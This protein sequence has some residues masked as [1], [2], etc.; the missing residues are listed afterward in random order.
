MAEV[1]LLHHAQGLT[2]G[3]LEFA[4]QLRAAGHTVHTPDYYDGKV[5]DDLNEGVK[6]GEEELGM[7]EITARCRAAAEALPTDIVYGGFSM[8]SMRAQLFA[9]T[10]PGAKGALLFHGGIAPSWFDSEWPEGVPVQI[11]TMDKDPW[12][13]MDETNKLVEAAPGT[14]LYLYPGDKHLFADSSLPDYDEKAATL[15]MERVL[16][17][18]R[19]VD[20]AGQ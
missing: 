13:E 6:Y 15:L 17:F 18:L 8:G 1:L 19:R 11:H 12:A 2:P 4:D 10:R 7:K 20:Q 5:F 16:T 14:E 9:Q 3:V